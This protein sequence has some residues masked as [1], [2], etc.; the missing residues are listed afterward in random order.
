MIAAPRVSSSASGPLPAASFTPSDCFVEAMA[1]N[2]ATASDRTGG[3]LG[4]IG[5]QRNY[6]EGAPW[7]CHEEDEST[8]PRRTGED[9]IT[10]SPARQP[11]HL[12]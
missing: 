7:A 11:T 5:H 9:G 2:C 6:G 12:A 8:F 10:L 3:G 4:R 1:P